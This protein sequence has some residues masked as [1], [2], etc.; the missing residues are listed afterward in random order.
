MKTISLTARLAAGLAH[1]MR[2][3]DAQ[4]V[5]DA[6]KGYN[7]IK[8]VR[9]NLAIADAIDLAN[10]EFMTAVKE[11]EDKKRAV[12]AEIKAEYDKDT[13]GK[14][15]E[16]ATSLATDLNR[17]YNEEAAEIQKDSKAQPEVI[18]SFEVADDKYEEVLV[19]VFMKTAQLWDLDGS[20]Q[21]QT[22]FLQVADAIEAAA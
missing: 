20:G 4:V 14:S 22:V 9:A 17:R 15:R 1:R 13:E 3:L 10:K 5:V 11:V 7:E 16:E 2:T 12:F 19:P 18:V 8:A 6:C 21:G